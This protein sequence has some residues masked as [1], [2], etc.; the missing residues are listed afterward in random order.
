[1]H[2]DGEW[3]RADWS[4]DFTYNVGETYYNPDIDTDTHNICGIGLHVSTL[5][6]AL[7]FGR[8][9][10]DLAIL[11]CEVPKDKIIVPEFSDGK[12]RTSELTVVREV[13]LIECDVCG[14]ILAKEKIRDEKHCAD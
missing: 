2:K 9:W 14:D 4:C 1:M 10:K 8:K 3:Y 5:G 11:E 7:D 6:F 13:P 12:V